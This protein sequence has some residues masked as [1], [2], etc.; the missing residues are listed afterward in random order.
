MARRL[1][2]A[3]LLFVSESAW[4]EAVGP[5]APFGVRPA[6][7]FVRDVLEA[8]SAQSG[9]VRALVD[10]LTRNDVFVYVQFGLESAQARHGSTSLLAATEH[11]RYLRVF[12]NVTL[13]PGRRLEV[14]AHELQHALE[15]ARAP[16]VRDE[17][18]LAVWLARIGWSV[19]PASWETQ[20]AGA[21]GRRG[22]GGVGGWMS[23]RGGGR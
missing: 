4:I 23:K 19:G 17:A 11:G 15:I 1:G 12:I 21:G 8:A 14:L 10:E 22:R 9:T 20:A 6:T 13:T 5:P 7:A 16:E 2:V 18:A 3:M